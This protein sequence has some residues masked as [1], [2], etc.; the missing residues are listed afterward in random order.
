MVAKQHIRGNPIY[1][2][3]E[4]DK[5]KWFDG[6]DDVMKPCVRCGEYPVENDCD[7]CL[8]HLLDCDYISNACCGHGVDKGYIMLEDGRIFVYVGEVVNDE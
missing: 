2:D 7:Y 8:R 3:E 5:W 6:S 1:Y 4:E